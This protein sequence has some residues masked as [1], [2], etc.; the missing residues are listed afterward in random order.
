[1]SDI[2]DLA[3]IGEGESDTPVDTGPGFTETSSGHF[4]ILMPNK[5]EVTL[6]GLWVRKYTSGFEHT[7]RR[8]PIG[9]TVFAAESR[10]SDR[11]VEVRTY[12]YTTYDSTSALPEHTSVTW[13]GCDGVYTHASITVSTGPSDLERSDFCVYGNETRLVAR[14][15][16]RGKFTHSWAYFDE[17]GSLRINSYRWAEV[18]DDGK[19]IRTCQEV[20]NGLVLHPPKFWVEKGCCYDRPAEVPKSPALL[21]VQGLP[22]GVHPDVPKD[23]KAGRR[24]KNDGSA[25]PSRKRKGRR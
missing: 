8:E 11:W 12:G 20:E 3:A 9:E 10:T 23:E 6:P 14:E 5:G 1:M 17:P 18:N 16:V 7:I 22:G 25:K 19:Q 2:D 4:T 15:T 13:K 21:P 24:G